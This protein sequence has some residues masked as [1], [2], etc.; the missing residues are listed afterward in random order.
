MAISGIGAIGFLIGHLGGNLTIFGGEDA[1]NAYAHHL[2]SIPF[3]ELIEFSLAALFFI[4]ISYGIMLT[5]Q[6]RRARGDEGYSVDAPAGGRTLASA[7]M[8]YTGAIVLVFMLLHVYQ[9]KFRYSEME[10][11]EKIQKAFESPFLALAYIGAII[12]VG[13]HIYHGAQSTLQSLGLRHPQYAS[14]ILFLGRALAIALT[15]GFASIPLA[16]QLFPNYF[17]ANGGLLG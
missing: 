8:I 5:W 14:T 4:H 2:H 16:F 15:V 10:T 17:V 1:I 6:N 11:F 9:M 7:T 3:L 13:L 12:S